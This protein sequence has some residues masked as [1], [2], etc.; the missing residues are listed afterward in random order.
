MSVK[1]SGEDVYFARQEVQRRRKE[2]EERQ[3]TLISEDRERER[4]LHLMKC[5]K[6]GMQLEE[7]S[8]GDVRVDQCFSCD[9]L[10]LDKGELDLIRQ[11]DGGFMGKML[12]VFGRPPTD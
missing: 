4:A 1:L 3:A 7:I 8:F 10:W 6:C 9:G 2:A 5:P 12:S 11:K